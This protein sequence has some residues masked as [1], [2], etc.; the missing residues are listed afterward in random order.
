M[1]GV[2]TQCIEREQ[3][4]EHTALGD[5]SSFE[6]P[7]MGDLFDLQTKAIVNASILITQ[8]WGYLMDRPYQG[9]S[10]LFLLFLFAS[11]ACGQAISSFELDGF[12]YSA[13]GSRLPPIVNVDLCDIS[14][15]VIQQNSATSAGRFH[16]EGVRA[17]DYILKISADSF[18]PQEVHI[19]LEFGNLHGVIVYLKPISSNPASPSSV[20]DIS[21]HELSM[22]VPA[23]ELLLAGRTKLYRENK[24]QEALDDFLQAQR[25]AHGYYELNYEIGMAYLNLGQKEKA[26]DNFVTAIDLST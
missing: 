10:L 20:A 7:H 9:I 22:P 5:D 23:H 26:R 4:L 3:H 16:F 14:G 18:E 24:P 8:L 21:L 12:V 25:K 15:V 6:A 2:V 13:N 1:E 19:N 11:S 17:A